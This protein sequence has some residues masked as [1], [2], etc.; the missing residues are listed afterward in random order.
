MS[1]KETAD[2]GILQI[3]L[4][5]SFLELDIIPFDED[6]S[7]PKCNRKSVK[8]KSKLEFEYIVQFE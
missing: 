3:P 6:D 4:I 2:G 5:Q 1:R 8:Q 7:I